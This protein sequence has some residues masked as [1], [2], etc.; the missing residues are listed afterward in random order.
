MLDKYPVS[1]YLEN[2]DSFIRWVIF[3]HNKINY[4]VGKEEISIFKAIDCYNDQYR[5]VT[6]INYEKTNFRKRIIY[7]LYI[8][9]FLI[10]IYF[11]YK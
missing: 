5:P 1:P 11:F 9:L 10:L 6:I 2:K 8:L 7:V 4:I 3:I